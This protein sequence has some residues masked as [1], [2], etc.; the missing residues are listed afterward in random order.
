MLAK[1]LP[2]VVLR[3]TTKLVSSLELSDQLRSILLDDVAVATKLVG[4]IGVVAVVPPH[5]VGLLRVAETCDEPEHEVT[6]SLQV[7]LA[8][9]D[10]EL[11]L[12]S[13]VNESDSCVVPPVSG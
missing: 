3:C 13:M 4:A 8:E 1:P 7:Q 5:P 11:Q 2:D 12:A 9:P 6:P 10:N